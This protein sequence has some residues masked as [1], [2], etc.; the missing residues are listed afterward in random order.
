M[1]RFNN[2]KY[3]VLTQLINKGIQYMAKSKTFPEI[4][5]C[6]NERQQ[7]DLRA[8]VIAATHVSTTAFW[9]WT[10]GKSRPGS[11]PMEHLVLQAV[12]ET[13]GTAYTRQQLFP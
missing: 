13:L 12:N 4:W 11:F 2:G 10:N 3:T 6:L 8:A 5:A 1:H 9:K 7:G